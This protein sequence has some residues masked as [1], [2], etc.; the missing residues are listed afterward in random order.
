MRRRKPDT[1]DVQQM[2]A[3]AREEKLAKQQQREKLQYEIAA[4]ERAEKKQQE[5]EDRI[6]GK[7]KFLRNFFS[8][9]DKLFININF[10]SATLNRFEKVFQ[11]N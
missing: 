5:Y 1:I 10:H 4:R 11:K 9:I 3:Q 6:K 7:I 2:K 8:D